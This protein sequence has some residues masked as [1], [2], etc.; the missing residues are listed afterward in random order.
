MNI[1]IATKCL[2]SHIKQL[3]QQHN[4]GLREFALAL[5]LDISHYGKSERH[6][7]NCGLH[8]FFIICLHLK[9]KPWELMET[10]L[11]N[12]WEQMERDYRN[13]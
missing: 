1:T 4:Y 10:A 11:K 2:F 9:V 8:T 12:I 7:C 13:R 3:R 6:G 5:L